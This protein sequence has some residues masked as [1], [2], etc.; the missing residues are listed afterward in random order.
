[1]GAKRWGR[2]AATASTNTANTANT[3][4]CAPSDEASSRDTHSVDTCCARLA[5]D[6]SGWGQ[7]PIHFG[8]Q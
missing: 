4:C 1:V 6:P 5:T 7:S 2:N 8:A 3:A